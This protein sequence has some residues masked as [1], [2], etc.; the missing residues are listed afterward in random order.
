MSLKH[1]V[2]YIAETNLLS[3]VSAAKQL[4]RRSIVPVE[5]FI[6]IADKWSD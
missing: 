5:T 3:Q 1:F 2:N 4:D 6:E